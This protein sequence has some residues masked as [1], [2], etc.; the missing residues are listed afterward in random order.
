MSIK[1]LFSV[2]LLLPVPFMG[3]AQQLYYERGGLAFDC[4]V[5][6]QTATC[7][8]IDSEM[9]EVVIPEEI[10]IEGATYRITK[11]QYT[12]FTDFDQMT[13]LTIPSSI[14]EIESYAFW[15][16]SKLTSITFFP[17]EDL[18]AWGFLFNDCISLTSFT[19]PERWKVIDMATFIG[20]TNLRRVALHRHLKSLHQTAFYG[21]TSLKDIYCFAETVPDAPIGQ[22][23]GAFFWNPKGATL[24][25]PASALEAYKNADYWNQFGSIVAITDEEMTGIDAPRNI[26]QGTEIYTPSGIRTKTTHKGINIIRRGD[27][28]TRKMVGAGK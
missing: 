5:A 15:G 17:G 20:C 12:G 24:H 28:S 18:K 6:T 11:I 22:S 26:V 10:G 4:S 21:C 16:C 19:I 8:G 25:V 14:Q 27:G 7:Y 9:D 2:L 1:H 23:D 13:S 3:F